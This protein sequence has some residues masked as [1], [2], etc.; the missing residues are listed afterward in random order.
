A[1]QI[2]QLFSIDTN[3]KICPLS[4]LFLIKKLK[5]IGKV[6]KYYSYLALILI[7]R[8]AHPTTNKPQEITPTISL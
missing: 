6:G 3:Q 2:L 4:F 8:F 5:F 7:R 1:G